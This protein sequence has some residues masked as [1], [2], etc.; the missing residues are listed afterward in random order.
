MRRSSRE[1]IKV[2]K[3]VGNYEL[4]KILGEGTWGKVKLGLD[5]RTQKQVAVKIL[6]KQQ[7]RQQ[8]MGV[9]IKREVNILKKMKNKNPHVVQ[10]FEVLASKS[11]IYLVLELVTGGELFDKLVEEHPYHFT[12]TRAAYYFRQLVSA[13]ELCHEL[14]VVHRDLKPENLLLDEHDN[15]KVSD[16]GLSALYESND[17]S[18][19]S[20]SCRAGLLHT[21]CGTP[22]YVAPEVLKSDGYDGRKA[23]IWSMGIILY[24]LVTG[25]L[26]FDEPKLPTLFEKIQRADFHFPRYLSNEISDLISSILVVDPKDRPGIADIKRHPWYQER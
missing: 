26:P 12:E 18:T 21:T 11:K 19:F 14:G 2:A 16:F 24:V 13:V 6:D 9:Q 23:D 7:I 17:G 5:R 15:L 25:T 3:I 4:G 20:K 1:E 10:L 22:N 8:N